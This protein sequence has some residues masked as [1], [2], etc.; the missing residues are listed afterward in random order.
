MV[1][2]SVDICQGKALNWISLDPL[3]SY[4]LTRMI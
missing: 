1:S 3:Q 2:N 4:S